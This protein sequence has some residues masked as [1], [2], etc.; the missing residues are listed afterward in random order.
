MS[1]QRSSRIFTQ[2]LLN[3]LKVDHVERFEN[4]A[5]LSNP[6]LITTKYQL[7]NERFKC[8][9]TCL[10]RRSI[11]HA[12]FIKVLFDVTTCKRIYFLLIRLRAKSSSRGWVSTFLTALRYFSNSSTFPLTI[13]TLAGSYLPRLPRSIVKYLLPQPNK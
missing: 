5:S 6:Q 7:G 9:L 1:A 8:V 2:E 13:G 12:L 11:S 3:E 4:S 10:Y